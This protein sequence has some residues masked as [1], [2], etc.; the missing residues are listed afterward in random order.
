MNQKEVP[1]TGLFSF[2]IPPHVALHSH[3]FD[4]STNLSGPLPGHGGTGDQIA[5]EAGHGDR[6]TYHP[7]PWIISRA[8]D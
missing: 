5:L 4:L 6:Q 8:W 2:V 3:D 1:R 7:G